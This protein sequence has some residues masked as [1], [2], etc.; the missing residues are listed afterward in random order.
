MWVAR[1]AVHN[2]IVPRCWC[3]ELNQPE[4]LI[5]WKYASSLSF[6]SLCVWFDLVQ[7]R[8]SDTFSVWV[9]YDA[10]ML[11]IEWASE[12]QVQKPYD[13]EQKEKTV[14]FLGRN[15]IS[16][17]LPTL[18]SIDSTYFNL[19]PSFVFLWLPSTPFLRPGPAYFIHFFVVVVLHLPP[20]LRLVIINSLISPPS[21]S[22][23]NKTYINR[24]HP[25]HPSFFLSSFL[26]LLPPP[27]LC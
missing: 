17:D 20:L 5:W 25:R 13:N 21:S 15:H 19:S 16:S 4:S 10:T 8:V 7:K 24:G 1:R 26:L 2:G 9:S 11:R 12:I 23:K 6:S 3:D 14:G 27:H 18:L 22:K